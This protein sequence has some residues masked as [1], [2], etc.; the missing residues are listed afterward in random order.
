[1]I[2]SKRSFLG[3]CWNDV[4]SPYGRHQVII[5]SW[6]GGGAQE[7]DNYYTVTPLTP[8]GGPGINEVIIDGPSGRRRALKPKRQAVPLPE[9]DI[10]SGINTLTVPAYNW[11]FGSS[12]VSAAMIAAYC[13]RSMWPDI[14]TGPTNGGVMPLDNSS[15]LSW[16]DEGGVLYPSCPLAAS[17]IGV[18][19]RNNKLGSIDCY[20]FQ[21]NSARKTHI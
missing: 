2:K 14:Y 18:D 13:D 8:L 16:A 7:S 20:W 5:C 9:P 11:V 17:K 4:V 6:S 12:A 21:Y 19:G 15:W 10:A 3:S 1:M